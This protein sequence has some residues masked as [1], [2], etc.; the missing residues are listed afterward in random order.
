M[1]LETKLQFPSRVPKVSL[2]FKKTQYFLI[3][4][5]TWMKSKSFHSTDPSQLPNKP[6]ERGQA[7]SLNVS[8]LN[9]TSVIFLTSI[10]IPT[11]HL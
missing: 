8:A 4:K 7:M 11:A 9:Y 3:I 2:E 5:I 6:R 10:R 1:I